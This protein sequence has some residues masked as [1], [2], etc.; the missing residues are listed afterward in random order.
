MNGVCQT[1]QTAASAAA[2]LAVAKHG[3]VNMDEQTFIWP[4]CANET[5]RAQTLLSQLVDQKPMK[6]NNSSQQFSYGEKVGA[7]TQIY[8]E[9]SIPLPTALRAALADLL[10]LGE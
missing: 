6:T 1:N 4:L 3:N 8:L 7:L 9:L 10:Q 5:S 2:E